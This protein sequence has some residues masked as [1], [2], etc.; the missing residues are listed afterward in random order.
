[1]DRNFREDL[2]KPWIAEM[3][4][5]RVDIP[6]FTWLVPFADRYGLK[7]NIFTL[8]N[9]NF[10]TSLYKTWHLEYGRT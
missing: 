3:N 9:I 6:F 5:L 4:K 1:M 7:G 2:K 8:P 10:Q